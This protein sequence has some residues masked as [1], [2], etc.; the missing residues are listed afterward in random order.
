MSRAF[1]LVNMQN[2]LA[3][4]RGPD[5]GSKFMDKP[6][7]PP[8][9]RPLGNELFAQIKVSPEVVWGGVGTRFF[10]PEGEINEVVIRKS[11]KDLYQS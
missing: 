2:T 1:V 3:G 5:L 11:N 8:T 7:N 9:T 4:L 6:T 10:H